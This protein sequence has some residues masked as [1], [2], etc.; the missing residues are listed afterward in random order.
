MV[1]RHQRKRRRGPYELQR[2]KAWLNASP[3]NRE[4]LASWGEQPSPKLLEIVEQVQ[5]ALTFGWT[6]DQVKHLPIPFYRNALPIT[7]ML[8]GK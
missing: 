8:R 2:L 3:P 7:A 5:W 4:L 6:P 1:G